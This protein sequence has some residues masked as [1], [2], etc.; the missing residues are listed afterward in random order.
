MEARAPAANA[1]APAG[2]EVEES[3]GGGH[4]ASLSAGPGEV[5]GSQGGRLARPP[6]AAALKLEPELA[7]AGGVREEDVEMPDAEPLSVGLDQ[8]TVSGGHNAGE[9]ALQGVAAAAQ[10]AA[11]Q[12]QPLLTEAGAAEALCRHTAAQPPVL[13]CEQTDGDRAEK[14]AP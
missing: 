14:H 8:H 2:T 5:A 11:V 12:Q 3:V 4:V 13:E 9:T 1:A 6:E 10:P 7:A